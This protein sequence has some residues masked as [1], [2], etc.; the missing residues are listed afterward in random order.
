MP[1]KRIHLNDNKHL[2]HNQTV[3]YPAINALFEVQLGPPKLLGSPKFLGTQSSSVLK[4]S[5]ESSC[6]SERLSWSG[7][8]GSSEC[9]SSSKVFVV[10]T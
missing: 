9:L 2:M 1:L 3:G 4:S 10:A 8:H 7:K 5:S 6:K